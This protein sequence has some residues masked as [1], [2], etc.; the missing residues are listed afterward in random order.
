[1]TL[2]T[3]IHPVE[4]L[5]EMSRACKP[6]GKILLMEHGRSRIGWI[7]RWQDRRAAKHAEQ[8]G[9]HWNRE[10]LE[11]AEEAGL[12]VMQAERHFFGIFHEIVSRPAPSPKADS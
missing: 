3:F 7:G 11:I 4:V 5:H 8:F 9:C 1:M 6:G 2:C 12:D 10:P